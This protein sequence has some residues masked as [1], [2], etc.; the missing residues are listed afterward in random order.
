MNS[1]W[2]WN[3]SLAL[4]WGPTG[5]DCSGFALAPS[6]GRTRLLRRGPEAAFQRIT[7]P[8]CG[9][10]RDRGGI[11]TREGIVSM[12]RAENGAAG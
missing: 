12:M 8:T 3:V 7:A 11:S 5:I 1:A 9:K 10:A 4:L 6:A 2:S